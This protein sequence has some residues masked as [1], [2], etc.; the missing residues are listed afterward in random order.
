MPLTSE[1]K[2]EIIKKIGGNSVNTGTPEVQAALLTARIEELTH[3][4]KQYPKDLSTERSLV[5]MVNKRKK[6][7]NYLKEIDILRYRKIIK[8]LE[9]RK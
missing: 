5:N 7:L 1:K 6:L 9:I 3:H 8:S 4:L 2:N